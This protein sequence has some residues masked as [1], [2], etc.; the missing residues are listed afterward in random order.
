MSA[1][2]APHTTDTAT[3]ADEL[4]RFRV[5]EAER[6]TDLLAEFPG[7]GPAALA[8]FLTTR[9]VLTPFQAEQA[10]AGESRL[11]TLGPYRVV[12]RA[13]PGT[14]GPVFTAHH[15]DRP[16]SAFRLRVFPLRSLWQA[17]QAKQL[18]RSLAHPP[19]PAIIPP[20]DV[21]SA[22]GY[23]YLAWPHADGQLL[24]D[25]VAARGP[26]SP[27]EGVALLAHLADALQTCH[28]RGVVH[29]AVTPRVVLLAPDG[30]PR[31]LDLGAGA[32]LAANLTGE[33]LL[34]TMSAAD[35]AAGVLEFS[36]PEFAAV[37]TPTAAGDQYALAGVAY[38]A[39]AGR[40]PFPG[41]PATDRLAAKQFGP[42]V[43]LD[44]VNP[45]VPP[46]VAAIIG[47]M[48]SP[49][50]ADRFP[51]LGEVRERL[52]AVTGLAEAPP[53]DP[54]PA[55]EEEA[56]PLA[57][58]LEPEAPAAPA[59]SAPGPGRREFPTRDDSDAS[60][61]FDLPVP[62]PDVA[63]PVPPAVPAPPRQ[64]DTPT[65]TGPETRPVRP[66][67]RAGS[68][69]AA[70]PSPAP[71]TSPPSPAP[72]TSPAPE[73]PIMAKSPPQAP[74][75]PRR[76]VAAP[77][78][79]HTP[80]PEPGL[81]DAEPLAEPEEPPVT[82]SALWKKLKRNLMFWQKPTDVVQVSVFGPQSVTP[83]RSVTVVVYAHAPETADSVRTLARALHHDAELIGIGTLAREV[84]RDTQLEVHLSVANAGVSRSLLTFSWRGQ[85]QRLVFDLHVPWEAPSGPAPGLVSVGR[86]QVR[87][88]KVEFRLNLL[89]RKG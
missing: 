17:R 66:L 57:E 6:L 89:P 46:A 12:D 67:A 42:P 28:A 61:S 30:L 36:S 50:P 56:L 88:G 79:Y 40:A 54:A 81:P 64:S 60:V 68:A 18:T 78:H 76:T 51:T 33:S 24:S 5:V 52:G 70:P 2:L 85:P 13:G 37:P 84:A 3:L 72:H 16:G 26:V 80:D 48:L 34:D 82:E 74:P 77:V 49:S 44:E 21:D 39:L 10:L 19:H 62:P 47:R 87:I 9:N 25:R 59:W 65:R 20:S 43:P 7:G 41:L 53:T 29:G 63:V 14:F 83:G 4:A 69:P 75:D 27:G 55:A 15:R 8:E 38:F 35:A 86:E 31:L 23:H 71:C 45:A 32:I 11:L 73:G 22:N 58:C 1:P